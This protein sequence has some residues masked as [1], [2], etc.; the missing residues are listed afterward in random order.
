M[1]LIKILQQQK[2]QGVQHQLILKVKKVNS[3]LENWKFYLFK[4]IL[5]FCIHFRQSLQCTVPAY[6]SASEAEQQQRGGGLGS[7]PG[8]RPR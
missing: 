1:F 3:L 6:S 4:F 2:I 7:A 5:S 8:Q